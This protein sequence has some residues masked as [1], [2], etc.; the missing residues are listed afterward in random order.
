VLILR[1][2]P[3][4]LILVAAAAFRIALLYEHAHG[5]L[6]QFLRLDEAE[7]DA[8]AR[9]AAAG[10]WFPDT[11]A[12]H[13]AGYPWLLGA[14]YYFFGPGL[15]LPRLLQ[16]AL[17][18]GS[19]VL[20]HRTAARLFGRGA[21][22]AA[23]LIFGLYWPQML[24]EERILD[25][26]LFT[27]LNLAWLLAAVRAAESK[28]AR[29]WAA[30]GV[31]IGAAAV[32]RPT[33][34]FVMAALL[35]WLWYG[36]A[37]KQ[38]RAEAGGA[39]LMLAFSLAIILPVMA[40]GRLAT[41]HWS[42]M[43]SEGGLNFYLGNNPDADGTAYARPGGAYDRLQALPVTEAGIIAP[44][45]QDRFYVKKALGFMR[46]DPAAFCGLQLKKA[47]LLINHRELRA[48]INP[49]FQRSLFPALWPPLPGFGIIFGLALAGLAALRP[50]RRGHQAYLIYLGALAGFLVATVVSSRYRLPWA[51]ALTVLSGAGAM[52]LGRAVLL[53]R[54]KDEA[55]GR[56]LKAALPAALLVV[57]LALARLPAAPHYTDAEDWSYMGDAWL[58]QQD[59]HHALESYEKALAHDPGLAEAMMG[60][61]RLEQDQGDAGAA[62]HWLRRAAAADPA[63]GAAHYALGLLLWDRGEKQEAVKEL[64]RAVALRPQ[65]LPGYNDLARREWDMGMQD[66]AIGHLETVLRMY[67]DF[68]ELKELVRG[69]EQEAARP[70]AGG[71]GP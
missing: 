44:A 29:D 30:T 45:G 2:L 40:G 57:G 54:G 71:N 4:L 6:F 52:E 41:G 18:L 5:P 70:A 36:A 15:L 22:L 33:P 61:A 1:H 24:F 28:R 42:L 10:L 51:A 13:G 68:A 34:V 46:R 11:L 56:P 55:R 47:A 62:L 26:T 58:A 31:L 17:G 59:R 25:A 48:T 32:V 43:Q 50:R 20:V 67:P 23:A 8:W 12:N 21:A 9:D 14:L 7:Y 16:I 66:Q 37:R 49:E 65:W 53:V 60:M 27:F 64:G 3:L 35:V 38:S 63:S 39:L 69:L 19:I